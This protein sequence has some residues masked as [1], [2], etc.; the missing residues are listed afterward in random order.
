MRSITAIAALLIA[1]ILP[2]AEGTAS[3]QSKGSQQQPA[4]RLAVFTVEGM[5]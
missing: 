5:T 3:P 1:F 4:T 2:Q